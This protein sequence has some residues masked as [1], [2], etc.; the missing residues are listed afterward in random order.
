MY[1]V[2]QMSTM[3]SYGGMDI[4]YNVDSV[5]QT[6]HDACDEYHEARGTTI[7]MSIME[8]KM[9]HHPEYYEA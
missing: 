4:S 2:V 9:V 8:L 6:A 1:P 7:I 5:P 3:A